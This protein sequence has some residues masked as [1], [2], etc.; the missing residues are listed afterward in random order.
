MDDATPLAEVKKHIEDN[1][2][3]GVRCPVCGRYCKVYTYHLHSSMVECLIGLVQVYKRKLKK[4]SEMS[5]LPKGG[6]WVHV[7]SV[8]VR[9]GVAANRGGHLAKCQHW[10]LVAPKPNDDDPTKRSSGYWR[11]TQLG[12]NFVNGLDELPSY[13]LLYQNEVQGVS[14]KTIHIKEALGK[15]INYEELMV[16]ARP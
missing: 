7:R 10:G 1:T 13:V 11:P 9:G 8:P 5:E 2:K 16:S 12:I 14:P 3:E 6:V 15:R 4:Y